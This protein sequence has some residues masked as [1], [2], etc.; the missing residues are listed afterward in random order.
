MKYNAFDYVE[1]PKGAN[2]DRY[3]RM[4]KFEKGE[5]RIRVLL[6]PLGYWQY[7]EPIL[8]ESGVPV[9]NE[10]GMVKSKPVR[11]LPDAKTGREDEKYVLNFYIW[12]YKTKKTVILQVDQEGVKQKLTSFQNDPDFGSLLGYDLK[13]MK[14]GE[15]MQTR[16]DIFP[17]QPK[18]LSSEVKEALKEPVNLEALWFNKDPWQDLDS[19][20]DL[21][22]F[23]MIAEQE[24][25]NDTDVA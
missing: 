11:S 15:G 1:A 16:Y 14:S 17:M 18:P 13:I 19:L 22:A 7:W 21:D 12:N 3:V 9:L 8:N 25:K 24:R 23:I 5:N 2:K 20:H 6:E 10:S 4:S